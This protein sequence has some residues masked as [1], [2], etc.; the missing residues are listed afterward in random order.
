MAANASPDSGGPVTPASLQPKYFMVY[1]Y[2]RPLLEGSWEEPEERYVAKLCCVS[3]Q[4]LTFY[5]PPKVT[6]ARPHL[7]P[8]PTSA[9]ASAL[10]QSRTS[11]S[12]TPPFSFFPSPP[13]NPSQG[14]NLFRFL[15]S[16]RANEPVASVKA[17]LDALGFQTSPDGFVLK[18]S[19]ILKISLGEP[20]SQV[21]DGAGVWPV[22]SRAHSPP[23]PRF[24]ATHP[25]SDPRLTR[26]TP[27]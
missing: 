24:D 15:M 20:R 11:R 14:Y 4:G 13:S 19:S 27:S 23:P 1:R 12:H 22:F 6:S 16:V 10:G 21:S 3:D 5:N 2:E 26:P 25:D 18:L 9:F 17:R 8:T 7:S